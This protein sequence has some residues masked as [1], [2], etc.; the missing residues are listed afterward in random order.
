MDTLGLLRLQAANHI[1]A[2]QRLADACANLS[3]E[4][5]FADRPCFFRSIHATLDHLVA[6]DKR[7]LERIEGTPHPPTDDNPI[8]FETRQSVVEG[9]Q[10]VDARIREMMAALTTA[11]LDRRILLHETERYGRQEDPLWLIL[12]HVFAHATHHR[13]QV[14]DLLSQTDVKPPQLDEFIL[15]M[16][17]PFRADEVARAGVGDWMIEGA[18]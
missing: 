9:R 6:T 16:D 10:A 1:L 15:T 14:H 8:E 5:Y 3:D 4:A 7:Y 18:R 12:Q 13:G 17:A 2:G 11:D